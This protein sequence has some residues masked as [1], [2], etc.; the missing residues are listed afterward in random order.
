[1]KKRLHWKLQ[2]IIIKNANI[3]NN[4]NICLKFYKNKKK[5]RI[6]AYS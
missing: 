4:V 5:T 1:M 3:P 2:I 6:Y